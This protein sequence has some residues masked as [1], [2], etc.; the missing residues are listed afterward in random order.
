MNATVV[1]TGAADGAG[2]Q[3]C[4]AFAAEGAAVVCGGRDADAVAALAADLDDDGA[5]AVSLR[6]DARDEFDLERLMEAGARVDGAIDVVVPW[7]AVHHG[8]PGGTPL[9]RESYSAFDDTLRTNARGVFAAVREALPHLA[10]DGRVVIPTGPSAR[11]AAPDRGVYAVAGAAAEAVM[12]GFAADLDQAVG[13][14][15]VGDIADGRHPETV[16][17]AVV[18]A[19]GVPDDELDGAVLARET[20]QDAIQ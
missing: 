3:V 2:E 4:R 17:R 20:W 10:A 9:S 14:V 7:A 19:A 5:T 18:W 8:A 6:A 15:D 16:A 13:C 1:V 12:R 11:E